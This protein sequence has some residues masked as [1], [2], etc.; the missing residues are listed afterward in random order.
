MAIDDFGTGSSSL[1]YLKRFPVDTLKIDKSFID[2]LGPEG[3]DTAIISAV[4]TLA[5]RMGLR[6]VAK[7][8]EHWRQVE[9]L[10]GEG[11]DIAQ[12]FLF[13]R[14]LTC[15]EFQSLL[16]GQVRGGG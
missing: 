4:V 8:V 10:L 2:A 11:C 9:I 14:P 12:G 5:R 1:S 15:T 6:S 3:D 16:E 13:S 7:G